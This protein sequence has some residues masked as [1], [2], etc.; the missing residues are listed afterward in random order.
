MDITGEQLDEKEMSPEDQVQ[1]FFEFLTDGTLP[2]G[3]NCR[4]PRLSR[5]KA[6]SIIWFLQERYRLFPD[7]MDMCCKCKVIYN[8]ER[9][10]AYIESTGRHYCDSCRPFEE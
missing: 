8:T 6:F 1:E 10:G 3:W 9:E 5:N 7:Y 2:E 4:R